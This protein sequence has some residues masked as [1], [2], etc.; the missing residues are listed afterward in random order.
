MIALASK[1]LLLINLV[2][3]VDYHPQYTP[4]KD[5]CFSDVGLM[6]DLFIRHDSYTE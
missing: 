5:P 3:H 6:P 1:Y 4:F 2:L